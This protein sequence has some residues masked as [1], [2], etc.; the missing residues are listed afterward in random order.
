MNKNKAPIILNCFSRGGSNILWNIFL[1]HPNVCSPIQETLEIFRL[2]LLK[3]PKKEGYR[4]VALSGQPAFFNQW[5]L[6]ERR[7]LSSKSAQFIDQVLFENKMKTLEDEEMKFKAEDIIYSKTEVEHARLVL[8]GNNGLTY[9]SS[10]FRN[11]YPESVFFSLVRNPVSLYEGHKRRGLVKNVQQ[12]SDFY[13]N[14]CGKMLEDASKMEGYH[15]VK[16]ESVITDPENSI[17]D[18]Y[19][20]AKLDITQV[21]QFRFKA[22]RFINSDGEHKTKFE[23]RKHYWFKLEDLGE[24]LEPNVNEYQAQLLTNSEI[25]EVKE[26]TA[27]VS[28]KLG[29][30]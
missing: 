27:L 18:L 19:K 25:K 22:K 30:L 9:L 7:P 20:K 6:K 15:I 8:K 17:S 26:R 5:Y 2:N 16:F 29:Y 13:N 11:I 28:S 14:L 10:Q 3:K 21:P 1:S 24:I 12:F 23:L 4:F